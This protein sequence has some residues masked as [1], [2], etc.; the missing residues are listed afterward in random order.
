MQDSAGGVAQMIQDLDPNGFYLLEFWASGSRQGNDVDQFTVSAGSIQQQVV[1]T[2]GDVED[3]GVAGWSK[4]QFILQANA[5]QIELSFY[6][7]ARN[8]VQ[9]DEVSLVQIQMPGPC[10]VT[11]EANLEQLGAVASASSSYGGLTPGKAIDGEQ[12]TYWEN[13]PEESQQEIVNQLP[14][15]VDSFGVQIADRAWFSVSLNSAVSASG[16]SWTC[17]TADWC[18]VSYE[19]WAQQDPSSTGSYGSNVN[20]SAWTMIYSDNNVV[21][22]TR[23][24]RPLIT[25]AF[26]PYRSSAWAIVYNGGSVGGAYWH[27]IREL[28]ITVC[29]NYEQL[30][31]VQCPAAGDLTISYNANSGDT[32]PTSLPPPVDPLAAKLGDHTET[33]ANAAAR[34]DDYSGE[35]VGGALSFERYLGFTIP[36][37]SGDSQS[38]IGVDGSYTVR[39]VVSFRAADLTSGPV[40][41]INTQGSGASGGIYFDGALQYRT[42]DDQ[43]LI[44]DTPLV[45]AAGEWQTITL[46]VD[47]A[48]GGAGVGLYQNGVQIAAWPWRVCRG[49][50]IDQTGSQAD[51][52]TAFAAASNTCPDGCMEVSMSDLLVPEGGRLVLF[53]DYGDVPPDATGC[54]DQPPFTE[55]YRRSSAGQ[56]H[57]VQ[58]FN[59]ALTA[60]EAL[61][62]ETCAVRAE[63]WVSGSDAGCYGGSRVG[64]RDV[65]WV[66][67]NGNQ[68]QLRVMCDPVTGG[69]GWMLTMAYDHAEG[70][71]E[72]IP[73]SAETS[74][75][76]PLSTTGYSHVNL[77]SVFGDAV[78]QDHVEAVRF[79]CTSSLHRRV[80]H[81]VTDN[82][83]IRQV[84]LSGM[85][86][87]TVTVPS[88][89]STESTTLMSDHTGNL[90]LAMDTGSAA[91]E[92]GFH[93]LPFASREGSPRHY[94]TV[95]SEGS[96]ADQPLRFECDEDT[97]ASGAGATNHQ[98]WVKLKPG[99]LMGAPLV[100]DTAEPEAPRSTIFRSCKEIK[101]NDPLARSKFYMISR[102]VLNEPATPSEDPGANL[103]RVWC[104]MTSDGGGYT[105]YEITDGIPVSRADA[106]NS[107][108]ELGLQLQV[109][110]SQEHRDASIL[111]WGLDAYQAV[112]GVYGV[113]ARSF[114]N[115]AMT[116]SSGDVTNDARSTASWQSID[117]GDWFVAGTRSPDAP[118]GDYTP[119]CLMGVVSFDEQCARQDA[120]SREDNRNNI[121]NPT[122]PC[123][124]ESLSFNDRWC[125]Y[126]TGPHYICSTNDKGGPG[127]LG[128]GY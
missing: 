31:A 34:G 81:F 115:V 7:D 86:D 77:A 30:A 46:T 43:F 99:V 120:Q 79:R 103:L 40:R 14:L 84:A 78:T 72:A 54:T 88:W 93:N 126:S 85:R 109:W 116:S 42:N 95:A 23:D 57:S 97:A 58:V 119:G 50:Y 62:L 83:E 36:V 18:P 112:P 5:A 114:T 27:S 16:L 70:D 111:K 10:T 63:E 101:D 76:P 47:N 56:L 32:L 37:D 1:E 128:H 29:D 107:C 123:P 64:M 52:A 124:T 127:V 49:T 69:G 15:G 104:D 6:A 89:T 19:I 45:F 13:A 102:P 92:G 39:V 105:S 66:D 59:R 12:F 65:Q 94:W 11:H 17:F 73:A 61:D 33:C 28:S 22:S 113:D 48:N 44:G 35:D 8:C 122:E 82:V 71:N 60:R 26:S 2:T 96:T 4:Y 118:S 75:R 98:V 24:G 68:H 3:P 21:Q 108:S 9:I 90:P 74:S 80:V 91:G 110:R 20:T 25:S 87:G 121:L 53:N 106:E 51:C 55:Q 100:K 38:N 41:I 117:G 125:D 67:L